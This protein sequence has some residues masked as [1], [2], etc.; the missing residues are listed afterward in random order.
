MRRRND[1]TYIGKSSKAAVSKIKIS[2]YTSGGTALKS[3]DIGKTTP[4]SALTNS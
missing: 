4:G 3:F 1:I 2:T